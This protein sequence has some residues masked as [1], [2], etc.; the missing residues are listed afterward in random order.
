MDSEFKKG[1]WICQKESLNFS[2]L[3]INQRA[4]IICRQW[5][6]QKLC[7]GLVKQIKVKTKPSA[8]FKLYVHLVIN[9][10]LYSRTYALVKF[11]ADNRMLMSLVPSGIVPKLSDP[12]S[13][14]SVGWPRVH[15]AIGYNQADDCI[16]VT[17]HRLQK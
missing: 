8:N 13:G 3:K 15:E 6:S 12:T 1:F 17:L 11:H 16:C 4:L 9:S 2:V 10:K 14:G 7:V 5:Q